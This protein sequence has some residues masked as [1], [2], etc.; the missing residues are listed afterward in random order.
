[1]AITILDGPLGTELARRG[2]PTPA[3]GWS[4]NA[5]SQAPQV[6]AD[7]HRAYAAAGAQVHTAN[8]FRTQRRHFPQD[9]QARLQRAVSLARQAVP[10]THRVAGSLAP[11]EDC[12]SPWLSPSDPRPE[13]RE[14]AQA[15]AAAQVDVILVETFPHV[16]EALSA[17]DEA[18]DTGLATWVSFTPGP[19]G[20]LLSPIEVRAAAT[21]A[22]QRGARAILVNCLPALTAH[23]W[24]VPLLDLGL[25]VPVGVY[26]NAGHA[27]HGLGWGADPVDAAN[28]YADLAE[29]WVDAG[30]SLV[31]SCCGT[32]LATIAALARRF[33]AVSSKVEDQQSA[34]SD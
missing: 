16:G 21:Q 7:I 3:P 1:M 33:A 4:A 2:V 17:V 31:G 20:K 34:P 27:D 6:V 14:L 10:S 30:A 15:L 23:R 13:Q 28:R 22:V 19:D 26:A 11:L 24:L 29:G 8:T 18:V 9:W 12:Y 5:L 25:G 32:G